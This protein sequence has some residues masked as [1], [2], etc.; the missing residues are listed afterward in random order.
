MRHWA[1]TILALCSVAVPAMAAAPNYDMTPLTT[2]DVSLCL[3]I[4]RE[5]SDHAK[6]LTGA[7]KDAVA[8][9]Q[10]YHGAL[11][12]PPALDTSKGLPAPSVIAAYRARIDRN[13]A[14]ISRATAVSHYDEM[15]AQKR[16]VEDRYLAIREKLDEVIASGGTGVVGEGD[17]P[18]KVSAADLALDRKSIAIDKADWVLIKPH[19]AEYLALRKALR[20]AEGGDY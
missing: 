6:H 17:G 4:L 7:D 3:S 12:M 10:K 18:M 14:I 11:P 8:L 16:G 1:L 19:R 9:M 15:I 5:A 20:A 2:A 13:G